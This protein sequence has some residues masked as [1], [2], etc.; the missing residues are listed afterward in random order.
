MYLSAVGKLSIF[1]RTGGQDQ[2]FADGAVDLRG[3]KPRDENRGI[4][5]ARNMLAVL[6]E[7]PGIHVAPTLSGNIL[8]RFK[9]RDPLEYK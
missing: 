7:E 4:R 2:Y 8:L 6:E 5:G 3:L 1:R 9:T